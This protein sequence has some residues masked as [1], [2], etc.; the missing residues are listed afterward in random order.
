MT[1]TKDHLL[2]NLFRTLG[3]LRW[4]LNQLIHPKLWVHFP[5]FK[6]SELTKSLSRQHS[7][8]LQVSFWP[9]ARKRTWPEFSRPLTRMETASFQR[10]RFL[11]VTTFSL[12]RI[13][14][15]HKSRK[16]ST[17]STLTEVDSLTTQNSLLLPW[18]RSNFLPKTSYS[19]LSRCLIK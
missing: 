14:R 4:V 7:P 8:S 19:Q 16:C 3:L 15:N 17:L 1:Q 18:T 12:E 10:K 13:S 9:R 6:T 11:K 5:T 2:L